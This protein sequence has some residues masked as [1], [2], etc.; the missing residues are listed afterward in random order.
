MKNA[1][2]TIL[3]I[4][5]L[6]LGGFI[7]YDKVINK[8]GTTPNNN[9]EQGEEKVEDFDLGE[10]KKLVEKY[11]VLFNVYGYSEYY[12]ECKKY[13]AYKNLS[14]GDIKSVYPETISD[15]KCSSDISSNTSG[16]YYCKNKKST[17]GYAYA[18]QETDSI[19]YDALNASY[20]KLYGND[21]NVSKESFDSTKE[22][23]KFVYSSQINSFIEQCLEDGGTGD[24]P[25]VKSIYKVKTAKLEGKQLVLTVG[26]GGL[27]IA[28]DRYS[29]LLTLDNDKDVGVNSSNEEELLD[30]YLDQL[31][32]YKLEFLYEDGVY[33]LRN[34][35]KI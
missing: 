10:A 23:C 27:Y 18:G 24:S 5:V 33:K 7:I 34:M 13:L 14:I 15:F 35:E 11:I 12:S 1:I 17:D 25:L 26:Y 3:T 20:K 6:G 19:S 29:Y 30:K 2:I 8:E 9:T 22:L 16:L 32:T 21:Q 31:S 28:H 4:L